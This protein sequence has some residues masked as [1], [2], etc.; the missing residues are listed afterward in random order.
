LR[1]RGEAERRDCGSGDKTRK[2]HSCCTF[3]F[4]MFFLS[5]AFWSGTRFCQKSSPVATS[6]RRRM[7]AFSRT[8]K[9]A[10]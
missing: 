5:T 6:V 1:L 8:R 4:R 7:S 2:F 10:V 3:Q 9:S